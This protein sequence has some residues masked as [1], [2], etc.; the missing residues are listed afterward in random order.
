ME[1]NEVME[2]LE[3]RY[4]HLLCYP[5]ILEYAEKVLREQNKFELDEREEGVII[6]SIISDI[7]RGT[8]GLLRVYKDRETGDVSVISVEKDYSPQ[9]EV[10]H[11]FRTEV[12]INMFTVAN[13]AVFDRDGRFSYR[14]WY[15]DENKYC[16]VP[17]AKS[18]ESLLKT[19]QETTPKYDK[20]G[21]LK[22]GPSSAYRPFTDI[23]ERIGKTRVVHNYGRS[24]IEGEYSKV[25]VVYQGGKGEKEAYFLSENHGQVYLQRKGWFGSLESVAE[26]IE[27]MIDDCLE[28][29]MWG[30][31]D[32]VLNSN[33]IVKALEASRDERDS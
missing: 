20:K 9:Y 28:P 8:Y 2:Y 14:S 10:R 15:S 24:P 21:I 30:E 3:K 7:E 25:G 29:D 1:K 16:E 18:M 6:R 33:K 17:E 32:I 26:Q 5:Q 19:I 4:G 13:S 23:V 12:G 31:D 27:P 22:D 11:G